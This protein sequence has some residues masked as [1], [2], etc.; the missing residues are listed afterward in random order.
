MSKFSDRFGYKPSEVPISVREDA[1]PDLRAALI[2][3][4]Y[5][6]SLTPTTLRTIVC[7]VLRVQ[8]SPYNWSDYP[9]VASEVDGL[10][11]GCEWFRVYDIAEAI[12]RSLV[13]R[14]L[15]ERPAEFEAELNT[16]FREHG[17]GWQMV[18]GAIQSRGPEVFEAT[19]RSATDAL[20]GPERSTARAELH[21]ALVDLS[22]RPEPDLTGALQHAMAALE[23][24]SRDITGEPRATLGEILR[25]H[26]GIIP[27]PLDAAVEKAW[28]YASER[29]RHIR[30][31]GRPTHEEVELVVG[32][33]ATVATYLARKA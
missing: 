31:G 16:Y 2:Q 22:R 1:P 15:Y 33:A 27:R 19:L 28:G 10:L 6:S 9:N 13:N 14:G 24:V 8:P 7:R 11:D 25:R 32:I 20:R 17:I 12:Y 23:C 26:P 4:A 18:D 30:E 29:A 21:E 5:D 3:I